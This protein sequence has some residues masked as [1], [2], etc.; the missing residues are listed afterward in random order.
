MADHM[1]DLDDI[2]QRH[3]EEDKEILEDAR[4]WLLV[5]KISVESIKLPC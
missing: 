1:S 2:G 3:L 5:R 4:K